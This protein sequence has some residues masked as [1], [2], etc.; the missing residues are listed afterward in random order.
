MESVSNS[1]AETHINEDVPTEEGTLW[2]TPI[3]NLPEFQC[4]D[5]G[6]GRVRLVAYN[7]KP[8]VEN[9]EAQSVLEYLDQKSIKNE[10]GLHTHMQHIKELDARF[11]YV[12]DNYVPKY[13]F[14]YRMNIMDEHVN[15]N[16]A[17]MLQKIE[18]L[19]EKT[20][21]ITDLRLKNVQITEIADLGLANTQRI[22]ALEE[23]INYTFEHFEKKINK[24]LIVLKA[25][26]GIS[27]TDKP[28]DF[29]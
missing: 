5:L 23:K 11:Q 27:I 24:L 18:E 16:L 8:L 7:P 6:D 1:L 3:P 29:V 26:N 4:K 25:T 22:Q 14:H 9:N 12:N 21:E 19:E 20:T 17:K 10:V 28:A 13:T 15:R 2:R